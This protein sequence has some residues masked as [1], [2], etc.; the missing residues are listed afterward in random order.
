MS[1]EIK[2][3]LFIITSILIAVFGSNFLMS[4]GLFSSSKT[5]YVIFDSTEG[6]Y[7][8]NLVVINGVQVGKVSDIS[9]INEGENLD[10][11]K[12]TLDIDENIALPKGTQAVLG[13][14]GTGLMGDMLIKIVKNKKETTILEEGMFLETATELGLIDGLTDKIVPVADNLTITLENINKLFDFEQKNVQSLNYTIENLNKVLATYG[15]TGVSL[16]A[17]INGLGKT[18]ANLESFTGALDAKSESLGKSLD[19]IETLTNNI[20]DI[21]IKQTLANLEVA[22][23]S[24]N[25]ILTNV[26]SSDN[27]VGALLNDKEVYNKLDKAM[28]NLNLLLKDLR[29]HPKRY[30]HISVFGKKDKEGPIMSDDE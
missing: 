14:E 29:L 4:K 27:T 30:V 10:R 15:Q 5:Y 19:N 25:T 16:N 9:L 26:N 24:L 20:K 2:V 13:T 23:K 8:S 7:K 3:A 6:L 11:I 1:K 22:T 18:L 17:K 12:V 28:G 21:E